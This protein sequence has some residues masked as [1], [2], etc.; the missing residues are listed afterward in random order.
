MTRIERRSRPFGRSTGLAL[1][2]GAALAVALGAAPPPPPGPLGV[3]ALTGARI[4]VAPGRVIESGTL[5]VRDGLIEAVGAAVEPP[6][7]AQ[8]WELE[9]LTIYPG[10]I[11][12]Y[13]VRPWPGAGGGEAEPDGEEAGEEAAD[14]G[15]GH[16]NPAVRPEREMSSWGADAAAAGRLREAGYTTAAVAPREGLLRGS[17]AVVNLG[18]RPVRDELLVPRLAQNVSL[19]ATRSRGYPE[20]LM[21][22]IALARQSF[23]QA[24]WY[25]RAREAYRRDPAQRRP[26]H[27]ASLAALAAA[28]AGREPVVFETEELLGT[29]RAGRLAA[30]LELDAWLVGSGEE[31][32]RLDAVAALGRPLILPVAFPE[33]PEAAGDELSVELEA[34]RHWR[35]APGNPAALARAGVAFA[36]TSFRLDQPKD[37]HARLARAIEA[38]LS[39]EA[40]LAAVTT[41]PARLLGLADR[42]GTLE[43]GKIANLVVA[44]GDLFTAETA[45]REVWIDGERHEIEEREPP[46]VEPAGEWD[47]AIDAG[48]DRLSAR[49][50]LAGEAP[51][52]TGSLEFQGNTVELRSAVVSGSSVEIEFDGTGFGMPGP[53]TMTLEVEGDGARGSGDGPSGPFSV[54]GTRVSKPPAP[55]PLEELR[56]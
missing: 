4:V 3:H 41:E 25:T 13:T 22:S 52:L 56:P 45:I 24:R 50:V 43:P 53:F 38:G 30:E 17:G 42:L 28:A 12:P 54:K 32:Q 49:L 9:G 7:D 39:A 29:L 34:L 44:E 2:L 5:V 26:P 21:G 35:R 8:V 37:L 46:E 19:G 27:D 14:P 36:V 33:P 51:D 6:A 16:P 20:S 11:D 31:Y 18:G 55:Q 40:A 23:L 48:G 1:A 47:L 15:A 10:L